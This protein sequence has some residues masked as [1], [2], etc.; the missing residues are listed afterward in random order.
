MTDKI[1]IRILAILCLLICI[2]T[3]NLWYY[4]GKGIYYKGLA[5]HFICTYALCFV[6]QK[7]KDSFVS[8]CALIGLLL[9]MHNLVDESFFNPTKFE[10]NEIVAAILIICFVLFKRLING[11]SARIGR[12]AEET[13]G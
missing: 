4:F 8:D 5:L 11:R 7:I 13:K 9:A 12:I 3:Y 1:A 10:I 2:F 6:S